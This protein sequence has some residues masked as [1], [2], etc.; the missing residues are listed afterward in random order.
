MHHII[1]VII[2]VKY[3]GFGKIVLDHQ[4]HIIQSVL[5]N[6]EGESKMI[7]PNFNLLLWVILI[8]FG[9]RGIAQ[10]LLGCMQSKKD[11]KYGGGDIIAGIITLI[12]FVI[13]LLK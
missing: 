6:P 12:L 2:V 8:I 7:E 9:L 10:L 11:T 5:I 3:V 4:M 13:I 1:D